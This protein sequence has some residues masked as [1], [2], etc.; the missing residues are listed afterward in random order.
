M[1]SLSASVP[2]H[3]QHTRWSLIMALLHSWFGPLGSSLWCVPMTS[4]CNDFHC[5]R[6]CSC[7]FEL[8]WH[9]HF[10]KKFYNRVIGT[11][12]SALKYLASNLCSAAYYCDLGGASVFSFE[13][14]KSGSIF[15]GSI[16]NQ[17]N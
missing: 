11:Q 8:S 16:E 6:S 17:I 2:P 10:S 3:L 9:F 5:C 15:I 12:D 7:L 13:H 1:R 14:G 4:S